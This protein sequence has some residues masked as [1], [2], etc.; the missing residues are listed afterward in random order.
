MRPWAWRT[1]ACAQVCKETPFLGVAGDGPAAG[2]RLLFYPRDSTLAEMSPRQI[3]VEITRCGEPATRNEG[4]SG[5][6]SDTHPN[7][8]KRWDIV[9]VD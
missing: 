3:W 8:P 1:G 2:E 7:F 6:C 4:A 9:V 5:K